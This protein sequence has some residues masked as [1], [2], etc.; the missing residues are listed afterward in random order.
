MRET[1]LK[2]EHEALGARMVD[3]A[4]WY[5][6]VTYTNIKEEHLRVRTKVGL[7]DVSH[8]GRFWLSG[9]DHIKLT[10]KIIT[11]SRADMKPG[12]IRYSLVL[13]G[14]GGALDDILVYGAGDEGTLLVVNAGNRQKI[15]EWIAR[16][17]KGFVC[18][19]SDMSD[20]YAM[21]A[22]QGPES[23]ALL[24]KISD[25]DTKALKYYRFTR[26]SVLGQPD[27]LVSRTGYT[28]EDG[29]EVIM[30]KEHAARFW[31]EMLN[32][33]KSL[34]AGPA[35]LGCRDTLRLE[36]GMPLY[37]H[38]LEEGVNPLEA[39]L[40]WAV[41]LDKSDFVGKQATQDLVSGGL[42]TRLVGLNVE[43]KRIPR[44]GQEVYRDGKVVGKIASG[45][46][47]P[48]LDVVIA[49]AFVPASASSV[50][51]VFEIEFG[52]KGTRAV[53]PGANRQKAFVVPLP[54]YTRPE[55]KKK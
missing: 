4:G 40:D 5:M 8:M 10:D 11:N 3:F 41:R 24:N 16:E 13:N 35:G 50:G 17:R 52:A 42:K 51:T 49:T 43:G 53:K 15:W 33:G 37:G 2:L 29:F 34:G 28:G 23:V 45:T 20:D 48:W 46:L 9:R 44:Q 19:V 54:F 1:P 27:V 12:Q 21:I 26:G 6:P 47:S 22:M 30:G 14:Q 36:A 55:K 38:E 31:R 18:D 39:G 25:V 7:F 32:V